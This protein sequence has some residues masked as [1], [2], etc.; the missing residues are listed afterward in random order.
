[1]E[2][3]KLGK[4]LTPRELELVPY[5]AEGLSNKLCADRMGLSEHTIKF[6]VINVMLKLGAEN[7]T[8]VAVIWKLRMAAVLEPGQHEHE[9]LRQAVIDAAKVWRT[10]SQATKF[11]DQF[12]LDKAIDALAAYEAK[13]AKLVKNLEPHFENLL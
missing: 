11:S 5:L 8:Q 7:R 4:P 2:K 6:H 13:H 10:R 12:A 1:M 9:L 3:T